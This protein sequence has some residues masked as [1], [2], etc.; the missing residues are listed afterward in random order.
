MPTRYSSSTSRVANTSPPH[1]TKEDLSAADWDWN[2]VAFRIFGILNQVLVLFKCS[3]CPWW[4]CLPLVLWNLLLGTSTS[5]STSTE[6]PLPH[7]SLFLA[8]NFHSGMGIYCT[9]HFRLWPGILNQVLIPSSALDWILVLG[10]K[11]RMS[12]RYCTRTS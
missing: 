8:S 6:V 9:S 10:I 12:I 7:V 3:N 5:T 4:S 1:P 2:F 11:H